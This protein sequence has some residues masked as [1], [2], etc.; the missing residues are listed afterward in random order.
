MNT[1]TKIILSATL[2][3]VSSCSNIGYQAVT[4]ESVLPVER[5]NTSYTDNIIIKQD[6]LRTFNKY[7]RDIDYREIQWRFI[8]F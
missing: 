1:L 8:E 6:S 2:A 7:W 4:V 5:E 3:F